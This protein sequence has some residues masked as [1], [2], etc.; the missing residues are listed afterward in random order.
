MNNG[1]F[2]NNNK[3]NQYV[4]LPVLEYYTS[5]M[6][7][8]T[9]EEVYEAYFDCRSNKRRKTSAV[10]FEIHYERYLR[11]LYEELNSMTYEI[12]TSIVFPVTRPKHREVF[13]AHFRDRVVHH[14]LMLKLE[15]IL[16]SEMIDNSFNC[17]KGKGTVCAVDT[18]SDQIRR[19]SNGY[20]E[21]AYILQCDL[22][23]FFM[24]IVPGKLLELLEDI[25]RKKWNYG[26][27][28]WW[29]WLVKK[30]VMHRPERNCRIMGN[31]SVLD[32]LPD[33]KTLFRSNGKGVPI[34]NLTSQIFGNYYLTP[35]DWWLRDM[36]GEGDESGRY[37]DDF[38]MIGRNKKA[39]L[40]LLPK[41]RVYL[42][43][44]FGVTLHPRK[45]MITEVRKG[46]SFVG[47]VI[48]PWGGYISN[49]TVGHA[50]EVAVK[51]DVKDIEKHVARLNSYFGFMIHRLT[52]GIRWR[53]WK[54][55]PEKVKKKIIC[56]NMRKFKVREGY[57]SRKR[58]VV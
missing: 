8:V 30:I 37:V 52:Y 21:K 41:I 9:L 36:L 29:L 33:N 6:E 34:G 14:L 10:F 32:A 39:L 55:I 49:R 46:V 23:G 24:S 17:R 25:I 4:V 7:Y 16:E 11:E 3:N 22:Q 51:E 58:V 26:N 1:G 31:K 40:S 54:A 53:L 15:P 35:F 48:K 5:S 44:E 45:I 28:E 2:N 50:F 12:N 27:L 18:M 43:E 47:A 38:Y 42:R 57:L 19:V 13:A 20:N 56:V